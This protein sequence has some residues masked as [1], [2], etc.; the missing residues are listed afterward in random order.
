MQGGAAGQGGAALVRRWCSVVVGRL[1]R[2]GRLIVPYWVGFR[3]VAGA[4][5]GDLPRR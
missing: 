3:G 5:T 4:E 1:S 2:R